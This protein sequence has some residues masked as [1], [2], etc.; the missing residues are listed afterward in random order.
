[1]PRPMPTSAHLDLSVATVPGLPEADRTTGRLSGSLRRLT[2]TRSTTTIDGVRKP[3]SR[4]DVLAGFSIGFQDIFPRT[5]RAR[6][7]PIFE[8]GL[9]TGS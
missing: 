7:T 4:C 2:E 6:T 8:D 5:V 3:K 1:M 9:E